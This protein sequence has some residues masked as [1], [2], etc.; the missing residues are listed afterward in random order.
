MK[1]IIDDTK[2]TLSTHCFIEKEKW[3]KYIC[4]LLSIVIDEAYLKKETN[5]L[6]NDISDFNKEHIIQ[7]Y[8]K[9]KPNITEE[10]RY[11]SSTTPTGFINGQDESICYVNSSFQVLFFNIF[12][13]QLIMNIYFEKII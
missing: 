2:N 5:Q 11:I 12:F 1:K 6:I 7:C 13:R 8:N 4:G 9:T 10:P 3:R